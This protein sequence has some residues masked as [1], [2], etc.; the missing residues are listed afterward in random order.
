MA[1]ID[2]GKEITISEVGGDRRSLPQRRG[3][4]GRRCGR[5][6]VPGCRGQALD[7]C[8][9]VGDLGRYPGRTVAVGEVEDLG[10][11][12][13][14]GF[15]AALERGS[16][17]VRAATTARTVGGSICLMRRRDCCNGERKGEERRGEG[18]AE[19]RR[20]VEQSCFSNS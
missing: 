20:Q 1:Q 12:R 3:A 2:R 11:A 14:G 16:R 17:M 9:T 13:V 15:A 7:C 4:A 19:S 6:G 8:S 5:D 10:V 18:R